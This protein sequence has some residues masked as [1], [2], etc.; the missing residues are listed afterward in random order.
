MSNLWF[1]KIPVVDLC[2]LC[3]KAGKTTIHALWECKAVK[4]SRNQWLPWKSQLKGK[5][6]NFFDLALDCSISLC[7]TDIELFC[8]IV[9]RIWYLRNAKIHGVVCEDVN[10]VVEWAKF[11]LLEYKECNAWLISASRSVKS[12]NVVWPPPSPGVALFTRAAFLKGMSPR[13]FVVYRQAIATFSMAPVAFFSTSRR[14]SS[15][16]SVGLKGF[17]WMF[18][19][20]LIGVTA[21]Q[22]AYFEGLYLASST[23]ASTMSNLIPAVTFLMAF[24]AGWEKVNIRSLRSIGKVVGTVVCVTGAISMV[25]LKG[26]KLLNAEFIHPLKSIFFSPGNDDSN[27]LLGCLLLFGSSCFWSFWMI[28]QVPISASCPDHSQSSA[29]M[30]FMATLQSATF[31]LLV[32]KTPQA[33]SLHSLLELGCCLYTG[34]G[35]AVSFFIQAWCISKRGPLF[36]AMFNPLCTVIVTIF[37]ALFLHEEIYI[38]S[39]IGACG[40]IMGLYIVLWGKA[41]DLEEITLQTNP[42]MEN[43]QTRIVQVLIEE[44]LEKKSCKIDLEEPL[45]SK[46]STIFDPN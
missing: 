18:V 7:E 8:T 15:R 11:F 3:N 17:A 10:N 12:R 6:C 13:V 9:W 33:W 26:T 35:L 14:N 42:K 23:M 37:A 4:Q 32:E 34:I 45:L 27:W 39:L 1:R 30:C 5:Y 43:D 21:N 29:W 22:N 41:K 25:L 38:G 40:V 19:A 36:C 28:L 20:S 24:I 16:S 2:P 46:K 31:A 44:P